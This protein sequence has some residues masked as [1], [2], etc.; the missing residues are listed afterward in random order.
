MTMKIHIDSNQITLSIMFA[1]LQAL[2]VLKAIAIIML[3]FAIADNPYG[4]YQILRWV[5][6]WVTGYSV[7]LEYQK[8]HYPWTWA[9]GIIAVLFN[10]LASIHLDKDTWVVLNIITAGILI[11]SMIYP[12]MKKHSKISEV[13]E[14][15]K[16]LEMFEKL[17]PEEQEEVAQVAIE[18]W[19]MIV[20]KWK[21]NQ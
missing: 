1:N 17:S 20:K 3:I 18:M 5:V 19:K 2:T 13:H 12:Y 16:F 8:N 10:P 21:R 11:I 9:F 14:K 6:C 7:Y 4:Y 15:S